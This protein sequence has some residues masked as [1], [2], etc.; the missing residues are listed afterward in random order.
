LRLLSMRLAATGY[1]VTAVESAEL[2]LAQ[3]PL[4]DGRT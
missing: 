2:A 4:L 3:L 1:A